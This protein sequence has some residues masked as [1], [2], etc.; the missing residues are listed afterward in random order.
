MPTVFNTSI[1]IPCYNEEKGI[2]NNEYSH[3]LN[4]NP[5]AF[6]CFVNDGSKDNTLG[7]LNALKEK[8]PN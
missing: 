1:V 8:H 7:V 4:N 6:I 5:E 3:F 2:S